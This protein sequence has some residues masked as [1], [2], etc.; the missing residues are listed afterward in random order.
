MTPRRSL[1]LRVSAEKRAARWLRAALLGLALV[2][3]ILPLAWTGLASFRIMPDNS[4]TP[5]NWTP[6]LLDNY[7]GEIG[8]AEPAFLQE[9]VTSA[10][11]SLAASCLT[12]AVSFLAAYGLVRSRFRGRN[13][14]AQ[15]SLILASLPVMAY[16]IP[17]SET[18]RRA[19]LEDTFAGLLLA[20][21]AVLAPLAVYVLYGY[22]AQ[23]ST[24]LEEA[25][26]LEGASAWQVLRSVV[27]PLAGPGLAATALILFV[28]SWNQL[29]VPLV[30]TTSRV[31]T[32]PVAMSDFFTFERELEWPTA[33]AAL[34]V[35]L[36][37]LAALVT[38]AHRVL[39]R[40]TLAPASETEKA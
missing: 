5:P 28:L 30:L 19:Q 17:L 40:F 4:Q 25:A 26:T 2:V 14:L 32:I 13:L 18:V 23:L 21:T 31:K 8:I 15:S 36:L 10:G 39:E 34:I 12:V 38:V 33:A 22:L 1:T 35:S 3:F 7:T 6:P 27:L 20:Q 9:L 24:E 16:I 29:L 11:L 37:P